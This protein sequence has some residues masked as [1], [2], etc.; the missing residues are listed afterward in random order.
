[1]LS[2]VNALVKSIDFIE[3]HLLDEFDLNSLAVEAGYSLY[4]FHRVFK[5][6]VKDSLKEYIRK[7]RI[8]EA[9]KDLVYTNESIVDLS[10]KYHYETRE[11]FSRSFKKTYGRNP[12]EVR[13]SKLLY[14]IRERLSEEDILFQYRQLK[15]GITPSFVHISQ[16]YFAG[17]TITVKADGSNLQDIPLFWS[18]W[19][20]KNNEKMLCD[21]S[22]ICIFSQG[23]SFEYMIGFEIQKI[24]ADASHLEMYTA[25]EGDYAVFRVEEP[26]I[27]NVQKTWD[28]IYS[29]WFTQSGYRHC[30]T[31]DIEKY[32][33]N[34]SCSYAE[35]RVPV[36]K[37]SL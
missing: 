12:S 34:G 11:S 27:E 10:A 14:T 17:E 35:L 21:P 1:M 13:Q 15:I 5:S 37:D 36:I 23:D 31:H 22:G 9:A 28:Y 6:I 16:Q 8:T 4:H 19:N 33:Y 7:R 32:F 3:T 24:Q 30:E 18:Q 29:V 20:Q 26:L 25:G 2:D